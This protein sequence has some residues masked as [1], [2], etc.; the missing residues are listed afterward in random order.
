MRTEQE[1]AG[2][3]SSFGQ[4]LNKRL[5]TA[6]L[7]TA[8]VVSLGTLAPQPAQALTVLLNFVPISTTDQFGVTALP[9]SFATWGFTG[10]NLQ[11]IRDATLD[12]VRQ[13]YLSYPT[14]AANPLSPLPA[15]KQLNI[16]FEWSNGR[17]LP[18]NG[19][20]EYFYVNVGDAQPNQSFLGQACLG[21]V[22]SAGGVATVAVGTIVGS[23]LSDS[24]F[25][26]VNLATNDAQRINLLAGTAAHEIGHTMTL[27]HPGS[28][29]ANPGASIYSVMAT[30][31][32]PTSMP[33]IE[34]TKDRAFAY[35]EFATMINTI[36]LRNVTPI[37][38][39]ATNLM[40]ALGAA[41]LA[42]RVRRVR[43]RR[44]KQ[45][46]ALA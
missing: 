32:A 46:A 44:A 18:T 15:G 1:T 37:P 4:C 24:I 41:A 11:G 43:Q 7:G 10:L 45:E 38:E 29:L 8:V 26:L 14:V 40:L 28:A 2:L 30:G 12:A 17:T 35:T 20:A 42:L 22:R 36:G 39:P 21:C 13:D 34:R 3:G 5:K 19:D 16:N 23:I 27:V 33:N 9:E 31:A 6:L 25:G